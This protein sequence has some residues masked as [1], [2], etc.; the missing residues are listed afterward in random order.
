MAIFCRRAVLLILRYS[1]HCCTIRLDSIGLPQAPF[2]REVNVL[3]AGVLLRL[4]FLYVAFNFVDIIE[5]RHSSTGYTGFSHSMIKLMRMPI[6]LETTEITLT[7]LFRIT[8]FLGA[9]SRLV[10][11]VCCV[12][13]RFFRNP[14][15][16][17]MQVVTSASIFLCF[18]LLKSSLWFR[19]R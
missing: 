1:R 6:F 17:K 3:C 2:S 14:H 19:R 7:F 8:V 4:L 16:P 12:E 5:S 11:I 10:L 15:I 13:Q 9:F 18:L